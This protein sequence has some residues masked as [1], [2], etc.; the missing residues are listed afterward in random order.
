MVT[1]EELLSTATKR[2]RTEY[3]CL[4]GDL[5][6][7]YTAKRDEYKLLKDRQGNMLADDDDLS[8]LAAEVEKLEGEVNAKIFPVTFVEVRPGRVK[9]L[10]TDYALSR[11]E[12]KRQGAQIDVD[13]F[14]TALACESVSEP[15]FNAE[16]MQRMLDNDEA[17]RRQILSAVD[18]LHGGKADPKALVGTGPRLNGEV[19]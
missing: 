6:S 1:A 17:T 3:V 4:D 13:A 8:D 2:R 11:D 7:R 19:S 9:E 14:L 12:Q 16:Q 10:R 18:E 15:A 5:M